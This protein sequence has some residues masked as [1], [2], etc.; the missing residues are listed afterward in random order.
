[1]ALALPH[2]LAALRGYRMANA[3]HVAA[4]SGA[5]ALAAAS[6]HAAPTGLAVV[7]TLY[8]AGFAAAAAHL[9]GTARRWTWFVP[10]GV[11]APVAADGLATGCAAASIA[12]ALWAVV[13]DTRSRPLAAVVVGLGMAALLRTEPVGFHGLTALLAGL[14]TVPIMVS[15]Y[16]NARRRSRRRIRRVALWFGGIVALVLLGGGLGVLSVASELTA[17]VDLIDQ[18]ILAARDADDTE[19]AIRLGDASRLLHS[20][21]DTLTSWYVLPAHALP[22]AGPNIRAVSQIAN[23]SGEVTERS[24]A[25]AIAADL[26]TLRFNDGRLDPERIERMIPLLEGVAS[27]ASTTY[28]TVNRVRSAWLVAPVV[29][30]MDD[31]ESEL[32]VNLPDLQSAL[33]ASRIAPALLGSDEPRRYLV[34]FT[35]PVEA[36]GRTGFPGNFAELLLDDGKLSM[37]RFGRISELEQGGLP[38]DQRVISGPDDFLARYSR[39]RPEATWRNVVMS[40]DFPT[41]AQVAVELYPQSGGVPI[42]GV[43]SVNP[44]GLAA[45]MHFT[46]SVDVEGYG[47]L[48]AENA[49][50]FLHLEQYTTYSDVSE[51]RDALEDVARTTFE[52]LTEASLPSPREV[53][54]VLGPAVEGDHI[55]FWTMY[56]DEVSYFE[57]IGLTGRLE[58]VD[59]DF[60]AVTT[61]NAGPSKI[62][63]FLERTLSYDVSWEPETSS[64]RAQVTS[65][66][67]N[68]APADGLPQNVIGNNLGLPFG[69]NRSFVSVYSPWRLSEARIDGEVVALHPE[70]ELDRYVYSTFVD[71]PSGGEV[72][73]ELDLQGAWTAP[74]YALALAPQPLVIPEHAD[75]SITIVGDD[76]NASLAV[77]GEEDMTVDGETIRWD[78]P[79]DQWRRA[80]ISFEPLAQDS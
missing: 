35:T 74:S 59:G 56:E 23:D 70:R 51:R 40:P 78:G 36:R 24:S 44:T 65:T 10:A 80:A 49:E 63:A 72:T 20:A 45:L 3:V 60:L 1:M 11:A 64:V 48:T 47:E 13:R 6:S 77:E 55:Q 27:S 15:G 43:M 5:A 50:Q 9:A 28:D 25:A 46:G 17:G 8:V 41:I 71:I 57:T 32:E 12:I 19:A 14:A 54:D 33:E 75:V 58:P 76:L 62:D 37:P 69:T 22:L 73:I 42:D 52:R 39:F 53:V 29:D 26:D 2:P 61:T 38:G 18:G 16:R 66:L 7:D 79:L 34:L 31:L 68:N 21:N 4:L 67:R 30:R